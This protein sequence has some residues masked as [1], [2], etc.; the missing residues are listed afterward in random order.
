M[1]NLFT[2]DSVILTH[3]V[4]I[5]PQ[6]IDC[7]QVIQRSLLDSKSCNNVTISKV[8]IKFTIHKFREITVQTYYHTE[9]KC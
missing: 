7:A 2:M 3:F 5:I 1:H 6:W 9:Y 4:K 8:E